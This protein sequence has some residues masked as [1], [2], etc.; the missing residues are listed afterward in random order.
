VRLPVHPTGSRRRRSLIDCFD[1][2]ATSYRCECKQV[3]QV[4]TKALTGSYA[5]KKRDQVGHLRD[6]WLQRRRTRSTVESVA[7]I[8][9][10]LPCLEIPRYDGADGNLRG[11]RRPLER[12]WR[13]GIER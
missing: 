12:F 1:E 7:A 4:A 13:Y 9:K 5:S 8:P 3:L 11:Q 6:L 10:H 2:R